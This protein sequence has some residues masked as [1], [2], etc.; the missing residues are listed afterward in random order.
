[1]QIDSILPRDYFPN[2]NL[3]IMKFM[4]G[5]LLQLGFHMCKFMFVL[6]V[7]KQLLLIQIKHGVF[8]H[9]VIILYVYY[10]HFFFKLCL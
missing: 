7:F 9:S 5:R 3:I 4:P 8:A 2:T 10:Y 6:S 1:M